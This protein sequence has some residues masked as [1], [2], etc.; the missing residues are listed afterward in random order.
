M[1]GLI[2]LDYSIMKRPEVTALIITSPP[3]DVD[4]PLPL[5]KVL[6]AK[7]LNNIVP[8]TRIKTGLITN[9]LSK[10]PAVVQAYIDDPL[11]HDLA[12]ARLGMYI[13]ERGAFVR[14]NPG[15]LKI[16][17]LLMVGTSEANVSQEAI[18]QFGLASQYCQEKTWP[19]L[20]HEIHNEPEH[21]QVFE[22]T[23]NWIRSKIE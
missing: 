8:S 9:I 11:V 6:M 13:I 22:F 19:G 4:Q 5:S 14:E 16:P 15:K 23:E 17:T 18:H 21:K 7:V 2:T 3:L 12:S 20:F 10:D 1:G